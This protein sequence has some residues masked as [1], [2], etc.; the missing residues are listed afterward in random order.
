[1]SQENDQTMQNLIEYSSNYSKTV[2]SLR[3]YFKVE[4]TNFDAIAYDNNLKSFSCKKT[5]LLGNT[6][7]QSTTN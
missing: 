4:I 7:A 3:F 6:V 5:K 2:G 1:M